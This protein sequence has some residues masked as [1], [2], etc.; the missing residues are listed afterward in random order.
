MEERMV[1]SLKAGIAL[2]IVAIFA[3]A[4]LGAAPAHADS[5]SSFRIRDDLGNTTGSITW[6]DYRSVRIQGEVCDY[7]GGA[8]TS[9][10]FEFYLAG[11]VSFGDLES[12]SVT[13]GCRS[14]NF[15]KVGPAG[16]IQEIDMKLCGGGCGSTR[17]YRRS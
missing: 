1:K 4:G 10:W 5:V 15:E 16:G 9:V 3:A 8:N 17:T 7:S 12:R 6:I 11:R 13:S 2:A 14:F